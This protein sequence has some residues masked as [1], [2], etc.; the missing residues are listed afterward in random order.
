MTE[1]S[2]H[3]ER[4]KKLVDCIRSR[5]NCHKDCEGGCGFYVSDKDIAASLAYAVDELYSKKLRMNSV[6]DPY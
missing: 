2:L 1:V 4:L 6:Q 3:I 5:H